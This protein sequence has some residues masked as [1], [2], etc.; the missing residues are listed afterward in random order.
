MADEPTPS[1]TTDTMGEVRSTI[2]ALVVAFVLAF[3]FRAYVVE[4]FVIPTGSMAPTLLG[5]HLP[6]TCDQCGYGFT[7]D[8]DDTD[9]AGIQLKQSQLVTCP[10]C[11][12]P[13]RFAR[14]TAT[15]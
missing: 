6:V 10:M 13:N 2:Q 12:F 5:R 1:A 8:P 4:A 15:R 7:T 3:I 11:H 14:G 9:L